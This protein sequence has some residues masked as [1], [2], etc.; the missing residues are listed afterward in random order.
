M[1]S[2]LEQVP[3]KTHGLRFLASRVARW[4]SE[5]NVWPALYSLLS[6]RATDSV[7]DVGGK[8]RKVF[9]IRNSVFDDDP[10]P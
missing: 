9:V 6:K 2:L 7:L 5:S 1:S 3:L 4:Q 10:Q 8:T